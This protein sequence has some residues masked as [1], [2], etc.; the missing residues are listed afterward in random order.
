MPDAIIPPKPCNM[1]FTTT[2]GLYQ[3]TPEATNMDLADQLSVKQGHLESMLLIGA[4]TK[5]PDCW[6]GTLEDYFW[7]CRM[8]AEEIKCL[9]NE[10]L[11]RLKPELGTVTG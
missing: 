11:R 4:N 7:A 10:L 1:E 8:A 6:I 9:T 3:L 2:S 5:N